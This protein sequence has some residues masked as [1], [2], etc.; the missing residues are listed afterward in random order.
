MK[1]KV[2]TLRLVA[3]VVLKPLERAEFPLIAKGHAREIDPLWQVGHSAY[4]ACRALVSPFGND[5]GIEARFGDEFHGKHNVEPWGETR[6]QASEV[7]AWWWQILAK[8]EQS[9]ETHSP[10]KLLLQPVAFTAYTVYSVGEAYD[11][12]LFHTA[13]HA[14]LAEAGLHHRDT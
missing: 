10:D 11:Y 12:V 6:P 5:D 13:Y 3:T 4:D 1:S 9:L 14:G 2:E 8:A 7:F